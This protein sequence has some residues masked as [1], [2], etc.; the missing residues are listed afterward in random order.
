MSKLSTLQMETTESNRREILSK[1]ILWLIYTK[2]IT[3]SKQ[4]YNFK[5][6][7]N[8]NLFFLFLRFNRN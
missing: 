4:I 3:T 6:I 2:D 1:L 8:K 7:K 5:F